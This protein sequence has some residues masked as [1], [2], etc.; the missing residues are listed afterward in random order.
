MEYNN[1][2]HI[3]SLI[4]VAS[5]FE[6]LLNERKVSFHPDDDFA[7]Y[8]SNVTGET[9]FTAQEVEVYNKLMS[10]SF[11]VCNKEDVDIYSIGLTSMR[12]LIDPTIDDPI[13]KGD[14]V[15]VKGDTRIYKVISIDN[16]Q[17]YQLNPIEGVCNS[18]IASRS[19]LM[20][21]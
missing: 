15:R 13:N 4:D 20:A 3:T 19:N 8:V 12:K 11:E 5:F 9:T 2:S 17:S 14:L 1:Q 18:V 6:H 10:E 7:E 16:N 21:I